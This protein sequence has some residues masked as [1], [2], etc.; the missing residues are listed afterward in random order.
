MIIRVK[1]LYTPEMVVEPA[2]IVVERGV[3]KKVVRGWIDGGDVVDAR[4]LIAVPGLVDTHMHG[5][6]GVDVYTGRESDLEHVS[7]NLVEFGVTSFLPTSVTLPH[8]DLKNFVEC[9]ASFMQRQRE[10]GY[11]GARVLGSYLEGPF[12]NPEAR[13]AQNPQYIREPSLEELDELFRA[14]RGT[15]RVIAL[16]PEIPGA[17]DLVARARELGVIPSL[18]HSAAGYEEALRGIEAGIR[19]ATHLFNAMKRFHHREPGAVL[20]LLQSRSVFLEIIADGVHLHPAVVRFVI[21]VAGPERVVLITDSISAAGLGD[22]EYVLGGLRVVVRN[23]IARLENGALAGSTLTMD[24]AV[25]NVVGLGL[26]LSRALEMATR[27][28]ARSIDEH[29]VGCLEPGC[30]ADIVLLDEGLNVRRVFVGGNEL[31]SRW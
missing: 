31:F 25:R 18:G 6:R 28:P 2:S 10:A 12:I 13:G 26:D 5:L 30:Y 3:I 20:A 15:L 17:L 24:R 1:R 14:S 23:G 22:G 8:D 19:R 9:V 21:D 16:A 11:E 7:R 27:T 4:D 29:G